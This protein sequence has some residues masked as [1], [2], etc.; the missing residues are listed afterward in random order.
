MFKALSIH[1]GRWRYQL[2]LLFILF[3]GVVQAQDLRKVNLN[4]YG[5]V[6]FT[7]NRTNSKTNTF[8]TLGEQD[9]FVTSKIS[10]RVSFLGESVI[11]FDAKTGTTFSASIERAQL[12]YDYSAT[13]NHSILVG[14]MHSPVNYWN[15]VYHHGRIFF[16]TIDRPIAFSHFVPLHTMGLRLQGQNLGRANFGYDLMVGNGISSTDVL[17]TGTSLAYSAS[18]HIKPVEG[19]RLQAGYYYEHLDKN[20]SGVHSGHSQNA[21]SYKG[22]LDFNLLTFSLAYFRS[23]FE[24]LNETVLNTSRT[25]SLGFAHNLSSYLYV[26]KR[27]SDHSVPYLAVD[28]MDVSD[29]ELHVAHL[30]K[31]FV[32]IGYRH[33]FNPQLY[34]KLQLMRL[35]DIHLHGGQV[36]APER[37]NY[38]F[39]VQ[40]AYAL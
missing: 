30:D 37:D 24:L 7:V 36:A 23:G 16:P 9:F 27:L 33:E 10:D 14:K 20:I 22:E 18:L 11:R 1:I 4:I 15:D 38:S 40:L 8:F 5:A 2:H 21:S 19:M 3:V 28:F 32:G 31:L 13:G 25:D 34:L 17:A 26:G 12:K 35:A 29:E 39:K 6:D